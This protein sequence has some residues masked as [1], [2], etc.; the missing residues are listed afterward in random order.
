[1][2]IGPRGERLPYNGNGGGPPP[3]M[4][5]GRPPMGGGPA[6]VEQINANMGR[7]MAFGRGG[8]PNQAGGDVMAAKQRLM[9]I[10]AEAES[11]LSQHPE[12]AQELMGGGPEGGVGQTPTPVG[13]VGGMPETPIAANTGPPMPGLIA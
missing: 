1:M 9:Q 5:G 12:L 4:G 3:G 6:G 2:P 11:I 7:Q 10:A 13:G 8:S